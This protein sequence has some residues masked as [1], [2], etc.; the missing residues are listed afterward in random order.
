MRNPDPMLAPRR[1]SIPFTGTLSIFAVLLSLGGWNAHAAA[2]TAGEAAPIRWDAFLGPFHHVALHLPIGFIALLFILEFVHWCRPEPVLRR[3][4]GLVTHLT[5]ASAVLTVILGLFLE[6]LGGYD[7]AALEKH[8]SAGKLV[9]YFA[10]AASAVVFFVQRNP[11]NRGLL[12]TFRG[13]IVGLV[14]AMTVAGHRGGNLAHG[15]TYLTENA[16]PFVQRLLG[17]EARVAASASA[18]PALALLQKNCAEC[19][20]P[21]KQ[22]GDLRLDTWAAVMAGGENGPVVV[23]GK[24]MDS[25]LVELVTLSP[26]HDDAMP[27]EGKPPLNAEEILTLIRWIEAGAKAE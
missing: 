8:E 13:L 12:W 3:I 21:E 22:K 1:F 2:A 17:H 9:A 11:F 19:H 15:S 18:A 25:L 4:V 7:E 23:P 24:P 10:M 6:N 5:T 27:P 16:P 26:T 14:A 20:G